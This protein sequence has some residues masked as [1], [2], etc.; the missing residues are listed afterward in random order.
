MAV[1]VKIELSEE[2]DRIVEVYRREHNKRNNEE[3]IKEI[4]KVYQPLN[5]YWDKTKS[6]WR[7]YQS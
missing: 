7:R 1:R 6:Y 2:E 5:E 4:I 3:A